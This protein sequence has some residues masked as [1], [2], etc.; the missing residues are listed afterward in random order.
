MSKLILKYDIIAKRAEE[1]ESGVNIDEALRRRKTEIQNISNSLNQTN[2][3]VQHL[4][5]TVNAA[6][7]V[8][9]GMNDRVTAVEDAVS[10]TSG[11]L[12]MLADYVDGLAVDIENKLDREDSAYFY[13]METNP[14]GYL[15]DADLSEYAKQ[16]WVE[17]Q[18]YL[19]SADLSDYAKTADVD[20]QFDETSAW[21]KSVFASA[22]QLSDYYSKTETSG[23]NELRAEFE[24]YQPSGQY[25]TSAGLTAELLL[26]AKTADVSHSIEQATSGKMD[27]STSAQFYPM[28]T[29]P[30]GYLT[31]ADMSQYATSAWVEEQGYL[32]SDDLEGY[33]TKEYVLDAIDSATSGFMDEAQSA[34]FVKYT[35]N[36]LAIG[37]NNSGD[38]D[39]YFI[40]GSGNYAGAATIGYE[41]DPGEPIFSGAGFEVIYGKNNIS[42]GCYDF[43]LGDSNSAVFHA[44]TDWYPISNNMVLGLRNYVDNTYQ[45]RIFGYDNKLI[46][47]VESDVFDHI[48]I[49]GYNN[50]LYNACYNTFIYGYENGTDPNGSFDSTTIFG[51]S[52][53]AKGSTCDATVF[54]DSNKLLENRWEWN[55]PKPAFIVGR[56]NTVHDGYVLGSENTTEAKEDS[57]NQTSKVNPYALG[58]NNHV[59]HASIAIGENNT[60]NGHCAFAGG[61]GNTAYDWLAFTYG[62]SNTTSAT[63]STVFGRSNEVDTGSEFTLMHGVSNLVKERSGFGIIQ[64]SE[65]TIE[66]LAGYN[67]VHGYKNTVSSG[68][69]HNLIFGDLNTV[70]GHFS[71]VGGKSN[72]A[73]ENASLSIEIGENNFADGYGSILVGKENYADGHSVAIGYKNESE[74]TSFCQ[75]IENVSD[76]VS[77]STG[78]GTSADSYSVGMGVDNY[79]TI[80]SLAVGEKNTANVYSLAIGDENYATDSVALIQLNSAT[81]YSMS[82]GL[83]NSADHYGYAM[84]IGNI[85]NDGLAV[86]HYNLTTDAAF[87]IGNGAD[88][89]H[90]SD[91][92][93]I[94]RDGSINATR[95]VVT[96][97]LDPSSYSIMTTAEADAILNSL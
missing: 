47:D 73:S 51:F 55:N 18:G 68:A 64:G 41:V 26:Y 88:E 58:F 1:T 6:V 8:V 54:G 71:L 89:D 36:Q 81:D 70:Y 91:L 67:F 63:F 86:G 22:T 7:E 66:E 60:A 92:F 34:D 77:F 12:I 82:V 94:G 72:R 74:R 59:Y 35:D 23:A 30:S 84:G 15:T 20:I 14:S 69:S 65:N 44:E 17:D 13:P 28:Y 80:G 48:F 39:Y 38:G 2:V 93:K 4:G 31:A 50:T 29:N 97:P 52:N 42:S 5:D 62:D 3:E 83:E 96:E 21:A 49:D 43:I 87:V 56:S 76:L 75:G 9:D 85:I 40:H 78:S 79:A 45:S 46:G 16:Q 53:I 32:T 24:K 11:D 57:L 27:K 19:K 25:V 37:E 95:I 10:E 61:M 90:R 33:A